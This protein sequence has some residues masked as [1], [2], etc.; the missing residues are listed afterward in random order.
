MEEMYG[1]TFRRERKYVQKMGR[2]DIIYSV[3]NA[4]ESED[5]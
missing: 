5:G 3:K 2:D 1:Q 4:T